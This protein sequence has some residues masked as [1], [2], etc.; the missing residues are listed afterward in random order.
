MDSI[1]IGKRTLTKLQAILLM[2]LPEKGD[3]TKNVFRHLIAAK[4]NVLAG[5]DDSCIA[6]DIEA[7]DAWLARYPLCSR[8]KANSLPWKRISGVIARLDAYNNGQLC[9]PSCHDGDD[10]DKGDDKDHDDHDDRR[11]R[12]GRD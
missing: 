3:K 8:V 12:P 7:A 4:L 10:D 11:G 2:R 6:E 1:T 9:A 5:A